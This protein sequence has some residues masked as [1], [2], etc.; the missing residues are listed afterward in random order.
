MPQEK[1]GRLSRVVEGSVAFNSGC[2][3]AWK[4]V[5]NPAAIT[6]QKSS[7]FCFVVD[8]WE[9]IMALAF[10]NDGMCGLIRYALSF[11]DYFIQ[12][13]S[14]EIVSGSG[15]QRTTAHGKQTAEIYPE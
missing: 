6:M 4:A 12:G 14:I 8:V 5:D 3:K 13:Y 10:G 15:C 7:S 9:V 1:N 11:M 2:G